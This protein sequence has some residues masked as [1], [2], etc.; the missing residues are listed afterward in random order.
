MSFG[1]ALPEQ[2]L[3]HDNKKEVDFFSRLEA[4]MQ[5]TVLLRVS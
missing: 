1:W 3:N 5:R 4:D 2:L